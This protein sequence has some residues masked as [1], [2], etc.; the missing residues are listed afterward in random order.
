MT[1]SSK[2]W[3]GISV[4][5][6]TEAPYSA[7]EWAHIWNTLHGVGSVFP[8]Y[9]IISGTGD[10]TNEPLQVQ[11]TTIPSV[12][13]EVQI[14]A[15]LVNGKLYES[16]AAE[17]LAIGANVSGNPRIDTLILRVDYT[18][19]AIRLIAKQG[20]P[21]GSPVAPALVQNTSIWE[22][23]LANIAVANGF[24]TIT[25]ANI[26]DRRRAIHATASGWQPYAYPLGYIPNGS[27]DAATVTVSNS[28]AVALP[29]VLIGNMLVNSIT[30]R[31]VTDLTYDVDWALY[32]QDV[33]EGNSAE[34]NLRQIIYG[35]AA[36]AIVGTAS[37]L[38]IPAVPAPQPVAPGLYWLVIKTSTSVLRLGAITAS[39]FQAGVN[40]YIAH[41]TTV[42]FLPPTLDFVT[43]WAGGTEIIA[44]RLNGRVFGQTATF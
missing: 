3:D 18:A 32:A 43:G 2:P 16:S 9:G 17:L 11:E 34:N 25:A 26:T 29:I 39:G 36:G 30:I 38:T 20:T 31:R 1:Q 40:S 28:G 12:N 41:S 15:A 23:P 4:G 24:S 19:Q 44:A 22:M 33:N 37:N 10:G 6:A 42:V 5:D 14:G 13:V 7:N 21:A 27:Y 35:Q 8:N